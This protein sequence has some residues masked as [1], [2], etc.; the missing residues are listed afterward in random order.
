MIALLATGAAM[1]D[2]VPPSIVLIVLGSVAGVSIA[3]PFASG[4]AIAMILL[5]GSP[6]S[7]AGRRATRT[8]RACSGPACASSAVPP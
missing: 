5:L 2:T 4:F 8:C 6:S 1:A 3:A 7:P